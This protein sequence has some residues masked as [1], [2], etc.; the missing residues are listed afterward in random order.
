[1]RS[2]SWLPIALCCVPGVAL[3]G[4]LVGGLVLGGTAAGILGSP[5]AL[6]I[7]AV[8]ILACP[9][10]MGWAVLQRARQA[11]ALGAARTALECCPPESLA[12]PSDMDLAESRLT[13]LR[14]RR[15]TL[16]M[17]LDQR[18]ATHPE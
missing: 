2:R 8:A 7:L 5:W 10:A 13:E 1:M 15:R 18:L 12:A 14:E 6:G 3:V 17:E 16:E 9:L 4:L 11:P